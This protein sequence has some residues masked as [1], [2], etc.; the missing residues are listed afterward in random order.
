MNGRPTIGVTSSL[1]GGRYMWWANWLSLT[2]LGARPVRLVAPRPDMD[3]E[4]F[5]GLLIGGGDDIGAELYGGQTTLD[6]R[7]DPKRDA[8]ELDLLRR[9]DPLGIPVLGVC[10]GAQMLNVAKG[11]SLHSDIYALAPDMPR[12]WT[13]LPRKR[14]E[15]VPDSRLAGLIGEEW[16][17]VNSLHHQAVDRLGDGLAVA[18]RDEYGLVQAIEDRSAAF[19]IGVQWHPEFLVYRSR[20][21]RLM[22]AL[23]GAA[24]DYAGARAPSLVRSI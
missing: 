12:L 16:L 19:R 4:T 8:L 7:I 2:L 9:A 1:G 5:D 6:V 24:R 17:S 20:Q 22:R 3:I 10:R 13:P 14:V 11:G 23:V 21:R 18:G 15:I